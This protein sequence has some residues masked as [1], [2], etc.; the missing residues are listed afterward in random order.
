MTNRTISVYDYVIDNSIGTFTEVIVDKA[1]SSVHITGLMSY[2]KS[3]AVSGV[4]PTRN[5]F[6]V[7][8]DYYLEILKADQIKI[9]GSTGNDRVYKIIKTEFDGVDTLVYVFETVKSAVAD[10]N[11]EFPRYVPIIDM[12]PVKMKF[13][14]NDD[15]TGEIQAG[16]TIKIIGLSKDC[17]QIIYTIQ[18]TNTTASYKIRAKSLI[19]A[20]RVGFLNTSTDKNIEIHVGRRLEVTLKRADK[21]LPKAVNFTNEGF[22][23]FIPVWYEIPLNGKLLVVNELDVPE[24]GIYFWQ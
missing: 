23:N 7:A 15:L 10:G 24:Y 2:I 9:E 18:S 17:E 14:L 16:T 21:S 8:G 13:V 5:L 20:A 1:F 19:N 22:G 11:L 4:D 6:K 12:V 3:L